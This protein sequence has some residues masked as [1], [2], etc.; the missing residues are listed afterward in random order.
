MTRHPIV[1]LHGMGGTESFL[2]LFDYWFG[3]EEAMEDAGFDVFVTTVDPMASSYVRADQ[4]LPQLDAIRE[5]SG[6]RQLNLIGHSQ[7][8]VDGRVVISSRDYGA[9]TASLTT[10]ATPHRGQRLADL[11]AGLIVDDTL[12]TDVLDGIGDV[13]G[14]I[15]GRGDQDIAAAIRELT[16]SY[17]TEEFNPANPDDPRVSYYSWNGHTCGAIE[18]DCIERWGGEVVSPLF[19]FTYRALQLTG[20]PDNDG[21]VPLESAMWGEFLG[22]IPADHLDEVGLLFGETGEGFDH[23]E[24]FIDEGERLFAAGH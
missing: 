7:G 8:G 23:I 1:L 18:W 15:L 17:M 20:S 21:L 4:L 9:F 3:V 5:E 13:Y 16:W 12:P 10:L 6:A 2:G 11:S 14:M 24:F 22:E 19:V